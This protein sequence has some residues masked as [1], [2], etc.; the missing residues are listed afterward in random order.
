[1]AKI[2]STFERVATIR[3]GGRRSDSKLG[4]RMREIELSCC[5]VVITFHRL[6]RFVESLLLDAAYRKV[7]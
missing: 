4:E 2:E 6:R 7:R 3:R 1:M 5:M